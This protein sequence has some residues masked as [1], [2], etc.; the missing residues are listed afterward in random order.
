MFKPKNYLA[1]RKGA[2]CKETVA[3]PYADNIVKAFIK[4]QYANDMNTLF[5]LK[6]ISVT[7]KSIFNFMDVI[8]QII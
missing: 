7:F 4:C 3:V 1:G 8:H 5:A 2:F 6:C